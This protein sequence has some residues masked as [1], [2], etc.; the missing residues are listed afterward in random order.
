MSI[1]EAL[2]NAG[3]KPEKSTAGDKPIL[4]GVYRCQMVEWKN[5]P[6]GKFGPQ[7]SAAFKIVEKL[8]GDDSRSTFPEFKGYYKADE[9]SASSKRNGVAKLLN[10]FFSVGA[11]VDSSSDEAFAS[12]MD[13]LV[14]TAEVFIKGYVKEPQKNIGTDEAP[15]WVKNEEASPK[16][17]FT[18]FT[19]ANAKKEA[20][21]LIKKTGHPL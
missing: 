17:D 5:D 7:V 8:A 13:K 10:G 15:E 20:A 9:K 2:K 12:S 11:N 16:Q 18:F 19:E 4:K 6:E 21:K 1:S 3:Y 14:G